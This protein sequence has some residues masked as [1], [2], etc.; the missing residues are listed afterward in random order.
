LN[1]LTEQN[2]QDAVKNGTSSGNGAYVQKET[3]SRVMAANMPKVSFDQMAAP[4][5]EFMDDFLYYDSCLSV[6]VKLVS[7]TSHVIR[8]FAN[9]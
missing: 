6:G 1:T 7:I 4:V 5:P 9:I 8:I 3:T 2:F